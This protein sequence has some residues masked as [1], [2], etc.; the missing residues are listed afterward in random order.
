[1]AIIYRNVYDGAT[2]SAGIWERKL[3]DVRND[4]KENDIDDFIWWLEENYSVHD[5]YTLLEDTTKQAV[6]KL[7][8]K[9]IDDMDADD[10]ASYDE[11]LDEWEPVEIG[12]DE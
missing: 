5:M 3:A 10:L 12:D 1:M 7:Y 11:E 8:N 4:I 2:I 6:R 9:T